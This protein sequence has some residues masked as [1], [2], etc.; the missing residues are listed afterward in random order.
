MSRKTMRVAT[1]FTGVAACTFAAGQVAN[2]QVTA[3]PAAHPAGH[4]PKNARRHLGAAG[5]TFTA[6]GAKYGSIRESTQCGQHGKGY[7]WL[8][9]ISDDGATSYCYGYY[10]DYSPTSEVGITFECGGN[11]YGVLTGA[12]WYDKYYQ[13]DG[14]APVDHSHLL[15]VYISGWGGSYGCPTF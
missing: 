11:N 15:Q 8:H 3:H 6:G 10:G 7:E 4:S 14:Y 13:G 1:L 2:A 12:G 9:V 5:N